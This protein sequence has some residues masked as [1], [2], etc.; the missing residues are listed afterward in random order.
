MRNEERHLARCDAA[1]AASGHGSTRRGW[2]PSAANWQFPGFPTIMGPM[3]STDSAPSTPALTPADRRRF[4]RTEL[5]VSPLGFGGAPIGFLDTD[6][7]EI[8]RILHGLLDLGINV[9]DTAAMYRGSEE[10]IGRAIGKRRD[11]YILISKC[12]HAEPDLPGES[13]SRSLITAQIDRSLTRLNT[14]HVDVMLLHSCDLETLKQSD[15]IAALC[16]ARDAGKVRFAGY[17]GDNEAAAFAAALPEIS[18]IQT[19]IN[20]CDQR[21][22]DRV[23]TAA[24][25][26][27][28]GVMAKRPI[29]NACWRDTSSQY[30]WYVPY[31]QPYRD[32]F[33]AMQID[34]ANI[35]FPGDPAKVWPNIALRFTAFTPG[36][37][38]A[39]VGTTRSDRTIAN[40][41]AILDG[42]LPSP[43]Y[44]AIRDAFEKAASGSDDEWPGLT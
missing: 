43:A 21:N 20:I 18:V 25:A 17:S 11:E 34:S 22:I 41:S 4:G 40:I 13:W 7:T 12:G 2:L 33:L 9:I 1:D 35:G 8:E 3:P 38:T 29:A 14:D 36:V 10:T 24:A 32:R 42:P 39:I 5:L 27:D 6:R 30:E 28:T 31:A 15:A 44:E 37:H 26:H 23:L 19:S 16:S